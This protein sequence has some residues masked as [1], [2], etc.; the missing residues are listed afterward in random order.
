MQTTR[1]ILSSVIV[2]PGDFASGK[3]EIG[4]SIRVIDLEGKQ[5]CDFVAYAAE[6]HSEVSCMIT[7]C[8]EQDSWKI[9]EGGAIY[10]THVRPML[11]LTDDKTGVHGYTGG[12]CTHEIN[13]AAGV[14]QPGCV[15]AMRRGFAAI[16][17]PEL[18]PLKMAA[19]NI[20]QPPLT[21]PDGSFHPAEPVTRPGDYLEMT[22]EIAVLW[23]LSCCPYPGPI[24]GHG[25]TPV[26]VQV[27]AA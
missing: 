25:P 4:Q 3:L 27:L 7:T 1:K 19:L 21:Q 16:G 8:L 18:E 22:A 9:T 24:N 6:D 15:E 26:E 2:Q 5:V 20:F 14:D 10:S 11:R 12:A 13:R 17:H 23:S